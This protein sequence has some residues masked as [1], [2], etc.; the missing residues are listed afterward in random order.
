MPLKL[1]HLSAYVVA[2]GQEATVF[3]E[4]MGWGCLDIFFLSVMSLYFINL[5]GR[6]LIHCDIKGR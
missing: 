6:L 4:G 5:S 1:W 3:A 2:L